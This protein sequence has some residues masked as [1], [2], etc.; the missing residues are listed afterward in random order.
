MEFITEHIDRGSTMANFEQRMGKLPYGK[1]KMLAN[2]LKSILAGSVQFGDRLKA[3]QIIDSDV[4]TCQECQGKRH[5]THHV[6]WECH[7]HEAVRNSFTKTF[8]TISGLS[9]DFDK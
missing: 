6:F 1:D 7:R 4:C 2:S 3:A 5:T 9:Q 8:K